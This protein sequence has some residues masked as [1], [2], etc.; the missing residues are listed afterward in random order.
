MSI[1]ELPLPITGSFGT[2]RSPLDV[3]DHFMRLFPDLLLSPYPVTPFLPQS[4]R[5]VVSHIAVHSTGEIR[6]T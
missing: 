1:L 5:A 3:Q 6:L 4:L 2:E